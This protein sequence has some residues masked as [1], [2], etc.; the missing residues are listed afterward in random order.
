MI[1]LQAHKTDQAEYVTSKGKLEGCEIEELGLAEVV[2]RKAE[3]DID[4]QQTLQN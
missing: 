3:R 4:V 1:W 2:S